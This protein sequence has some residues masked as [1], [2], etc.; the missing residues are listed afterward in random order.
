MISI[1]EDAPWLKSE[2]Y[3]LILQCQSKTPKLRSYLTENGWRI[4]EEAVLRDGRFLYTVM[5][6]R[7]EPDC[8][9]L[10]EAECYFPPVLLEHPG[11]ELTEYYSRI[12]EGLR[13]AV[14]HQNDGEKKAI[15]E[16]L[17]KIEW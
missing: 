17:E 6:V 12:V 13:L 9:R 4:G 15:L 7:Y 3:T 2:R 5:K 10:T 8:P 11:Q 1:L 14:T 16:E